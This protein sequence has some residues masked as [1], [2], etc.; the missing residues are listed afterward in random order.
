MP[1]L[2]QASKRLERI[3][4]KA[5][6]SLFAEDFEHR[7]CSLR[8]EASENT[9]LWIEK[10]LKNPV[11]LAWKEPLFFDELKLNAVFKCKVVLTKIYD[12]KEPHKKIYR[13]RIEGSYIPR[14]SSKKHSHVFYLTLQA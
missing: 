14:G 2:P 4:L 3:K 9:H 13:Y 12:S 8:E 10:S 1:F 11:I 7:V 6:S 5:A